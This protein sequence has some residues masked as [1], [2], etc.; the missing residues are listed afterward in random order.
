MGT[1]GELDTTV[2][3]YRNIY[4]HAKKLHFEVIHISWS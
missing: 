3:I 1:L 4:C 2:L